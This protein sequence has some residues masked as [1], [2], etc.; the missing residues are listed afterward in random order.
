MFL[1]GFILKKFYSF[2]KEYIHIFFLMAVIFSVVIYTYNK[3]TVTAML[4]VSGKT[5][6]ID[7]GHGGWDPG[8]T[9]T[10]GENEKIINLEIAKKLQ[11][12]LET[13]GANVVITRH[14]DDAL[15]ENKRADMK[16]RKNIADESKGDILISIHQNSFP[17][18]KAKGAQVFYYKTSEESKKL[19]ERVQSRL[20]SDADE[21]NTRQAKGNTDYYM[22]KSMEM[23]CIIVEC[24]FL[25]NY[26]EEK[27]LNDKGYQQKI[28]WAI[29][30]GVVE[31][32][33]DK[34]SI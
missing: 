21:N 14:N 8:K 10:E 16:E 18:K 4:P 1:G 33:N 34:D 7:A 3:N 19:A 32:F 28:A 23:P 12:Y 11:E 25:S 17:S 22:L 24:G 27:L 9:G 30:M 31:Y 15:G 5:I 20:I 26:E 29:Y 13:A 2:K 6:V